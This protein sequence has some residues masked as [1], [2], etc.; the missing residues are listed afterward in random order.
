[1]DPSLLERSN[2]I[3]V[4]LNGRDGKKQ[5]PKSFVSRL[6]GIHLITLATQGLALVE[7]LQHVHFRKYVLDET[8]LTTL[9]RLMNSLWKEILEKKLYTITE[10]KNWVPYDKIKRS[11]KISN[12]IPHLVR[13]PISGWQFAAR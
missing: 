8:Q 6:S 5:V 12:E 10:G 11:R 1:M 2:R 7:G 13:S 9:E 3:V 4:A